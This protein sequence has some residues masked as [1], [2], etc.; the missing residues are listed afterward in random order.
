MS[1]GEVKPL[2][3]HPPCPPK[4]VQGDDCP[5]CPNQGWYYIG[6]Y[7]EQE[8]CEWCWVNSDSKFSKNDFKRCNSYK[9]D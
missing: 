8:Q 1:K 6:P 9:A 2:T 4:Q 3:P 5:D 7:G